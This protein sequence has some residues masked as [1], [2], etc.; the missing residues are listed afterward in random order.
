MFHTILVSSPSNYFFFLFN[1]LIVGVGVGG[2]VVVCMCVWECN[3]Y[4]CVCV[5]SKVCIRLP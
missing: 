3:V 4:D 2:W 5:V 1:L